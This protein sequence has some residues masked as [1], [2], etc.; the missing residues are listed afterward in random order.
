MADKVETSGCTQ[1]EPAQQGA[2]DPGQVST[3]ACGCSRSGS[4]AQFVYAFG[5]LG[6]DF[7]T[8]ARRDSILQH[9]K[10][11][12]KGV[13][14]NPYDPRQLLNYLAKN[15]WDA[16]AII[17]TLNLD[18]TPVYALRP[19]G[20]FANETYQRLHQFLTETMEEGVERVSVPGVIVGNARLFTGQVVSVIQPDLRCMYSWSTKA[21]IHAVF[22]SPPSA[23]AEDEEK[24]EYIEK[25]KAITGF[26]ERVYYQLRN[27]GVL[28]E[29][30]AINSAATNAFQV[31][32]VFEA[33]I[34]EHMDLDTIA[35]ERSPICRLGSDCWDV[36]LA[37]FN[38]KKILEQARKV[39]RFTVDVSDICPVAVGPV[40]SW[41]VR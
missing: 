38:P 17:W 10:E 19:Q 11:P 2:V 30:R 25:S 28:P 8:E 3:P 1:E 13:P 21:L 29:D 36:V 32:K 22:G 26:L 40:R 41:F 27:L 6:Y 39:Y 31:A 20:P 7:G 23:T 34:K 37:F 12:A 4:P 24:K 33:A 9:M 35:V 5:Q 18:A 14:P 15:P 16:A